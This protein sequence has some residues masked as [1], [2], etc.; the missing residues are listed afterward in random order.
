M[1]SNPGSVY[2]EI[3]DRLASLGGFFVGDPP[4]ATPPPYT[5]VWGPGMIQDAPTFGGLRT[6][7]R[8]LHVTVVHTTPNNA[9]LLASQAEE[10]LSG[11]VPTVDG[12]VFSPLTVTG[13]EPVQTA[14]SV[15]ETDT[16]RSAAWLV[17]HVRLRGQQIG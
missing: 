4:N 8:R 10:L 6:V 3:A 15:V 13:S 11:F 16:N 17:L 14:H 9:L 2:Q 7:D 12:W 1:T 5:F